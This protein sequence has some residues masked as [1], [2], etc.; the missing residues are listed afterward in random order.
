VQQYSDYGVNADGSQWT[1]LYT[2]PAG[3]NSPVWTKTTID[4]L[5][6]T[7]REERPG[8]GGGIITNA[9]IYNSKNQLIKTQVS[10]F[11]PQPPASLYEYN[12]LGEQIRS[13]L[14]VDGNGVLD[15][16]GMD[17]IS[18]SDTQFV[19]DASNDWFKVAVSRLY[20]KNN[21]ST[22]TTN[23][24]QKTR[25]TGLG[26]A[27]GSGLLTADSR[28]VDIF[29]NQTIST[30]AVDR[31]NKAVTQTTIYPDSTNS[32]FSVTVNGLLVCSTGKT[33]LQTAFGSDGLERQTG[34]IDPRT[35][36]RVTHYNEKGQ[37]DWTQDSATNQTS[38]GYDSATGRRI[39]M[40]DALSNTVYTA[41]DSK[42]QVLATWGATYPVAYEFDE[43][44]RMSAMYT[45]RGTNPIAAYSDICNLKS[46]MDKT[47]WLYDLATGLLTN[48]VY[49]DGKGPGY[50]YT[51]DGKL[52]TRTWARGV[53]TTYSWDSLGQMTNIDYSSSAPNVSFAFN[54]I[55]QQTTITDGTGSR[56]FTYNDQLQLAAETNALAGIQR[57]YDS[58]GRSSG[59]SLADGSYAVQYSYS[60]VGRF[61]GISST[62]NG[63]SNGWQY[64]YLPDSELIVGW[65]NGVVSVSKSYDPSRNLI[66]EILNQAGSNVI[67]R[68]QYSNDQLGRRTQRIDN[69]SA[70]NSF[71]YNTRSELTAAAMG[72][73]NYGYQYD[74]IGNRITA[75]NNAEV[76]TYLANA[77][78][79]YTNI[80]DGVTSMPTYDLDGNMV[81]FGG[82]TFGWDGENRL[83][84]AEPVAPTGGARR[85][86]CFYDFMSRRVGKAVDEWNGSAWVAA[87][88]NLFQYDGWNL[89]S[90]TQVSGL[91]TQVSR[92][93]WGL[94]LSGSLQG[95]GGIDGLLSVTRSTPSGTFTYYPCADGN[96]NIPEYLDTNGIVVAH[97]EYD[98]YGNTIASSGA[99]N[100]FDFWFSSKYLDP[101][102]GLVYFGYRYYC[103][104]IGRWIS[105]DPSEEEADHHLY[106]FV[107]NRSV[108][109]VDNDG[110]FVWI[111]KWCIRK[112]IPTPSLGGPLIPTTYSLISDTP[113]Y[114]GSPPV[115]LYRIC[116]YQATCPHYSDE[117]GT[118]YTITGKTMKPCPLHGLPAVFIPVTP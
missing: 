58:L 70:T 105:R 112:C 23:G 115:F 24:V 87:S 116:E 86:R 71:G 98:P 84:L 117:I 94:D 100:D 36:T 49:A 37:V 60:G 75:T 64:S 101:E 19:K 80:H 1:I 43:Y 45:Y 2:G 63:Q 85:V 16:N 97:R 7:I 29:G 104:L 13:G 103:P 26:I 56:A 93:V 91:S 109:F 83:I 102:T 67:S 46:S 6:R 95:E 18:E 88:T 51:A 81:T 28:S 17:R 55:G 10:G 77:L 89:V 40:T 57:G 52:A 27:I 30:T 48:K 31:N 108:D 20:A 39:S 90:E 82:W 106:L 4:L 61:A 62:V 113:V 41:Y 114:T 21:D 44:D 110:R 33:G 59:F 38:F 11:S 73:N 99:V 118:T 32:A 12:Q 47:S 66:I 34:V 22:V 25:L 8:F 3:T 14:D 69:S 42:G 5:G 96:G 72:T 68:F 35:G 111:I 65:N 74:P 53:V 54:R 15:L 92:Y 79:Q 76:L 50:T 107:R 78:N 9:S